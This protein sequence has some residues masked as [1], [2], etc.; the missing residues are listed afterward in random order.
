M[1]KLMRVTAVTLVVSILFSGNSLITAKTEKKTRIKDKTVT[2]NVGQKKSIKL[3]NKKKK[4]KYLFQSSKTK[5]VKVSK[6]GVMTAFKEGKAKI[7]VKEKRGKKT[8]RIGTVSVTVKKAVKPSP[9]PEQKA[10]PTPVSTPAAPI[11][12]PINENPAVSPQAPTSDPGQTET[13]PTPTPK[14]PVNPEIKDTPEKL[15]RTQS[16]VSYGEVIKTEYYSKTT[17]KNRKVNVIL[18]EGYTD[19]EEYPV[20]YLFH[21]GMGDENDWISGNVRYMIGNMIASGEAKEMIVVMPNCRCR[22]NDAANPSDGFA[23]EHVQSFDKF[24]DDFKDNL[25]P[26]IEST[27][28][29]AKGRDNTAIAGL[30]MGGRVALNIGFS[31]PDQVGYIGAFSPAYG[32]FHYT[33]NG[34]TEEGLFTEETFTLPD[35]YKNSTYVLINNGNQ[36]SMVKKEPQRYHDALEANEVHHTFYTLD[37]GHDWV[38]WKNGFYNFARYLF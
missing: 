27:Y 14:P 38:V 9:V 19:E 28:S 11:A 6:K 3:R 29:V 5:T 37:G 1:R 18:P 7:T 10:T 36:D 24:L 23:P 21:G 2:M 32:I 13:P 4:A 15:D 8:K 25:M 35:H 17:E 30:S 22:E 26:F 16:G 12:T 31:L 33:N 34:L 20:I